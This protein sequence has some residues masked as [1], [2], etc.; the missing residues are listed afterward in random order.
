MN[1]YIEKLYSIYKQLPES[2]GCIG[3]G[4]CCKV[5]YPHCYF[6]EFI[7]IYNHINTNWNDHD[8]KELHIR[9]VEKYIS[10]DLKKK[11]V[12]LDKNNKCKIYEQRDFNCRAFGIIPKKVYTERVKEAKKKFGNVNL[13]LQSQSECP[14]KIHPAI[15]IGKNKLHQLFT[16]IYDLDVKLGIPKED[17]KEANNYMTFH[18]HYL[19]N[20]YKTHRD[21]LENLT[22]VKL[23]F[24]DEEKKDFCKRMRDHLEMGEENEK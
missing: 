2:V 22:N 17:L 18:D 11:C 10:N 4:K 19:L 8:K 9:C 24:S 6:I 21:I 23:N 15:F 14:G 16:E 20:Y 13:P 5:Q 12:F 7:N 3:C 1:K